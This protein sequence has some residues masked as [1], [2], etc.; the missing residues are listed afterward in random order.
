MVD[1]DDR[2]HVAI[3]SYRRAGRV[4]TLKPFPFAYVWVP[5]LRYD[6]AIQAKDDYDFW[7]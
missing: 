2:I 1:I 4:D 7:L 5:E 3:R 6:E